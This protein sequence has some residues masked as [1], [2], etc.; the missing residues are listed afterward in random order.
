MEFLN[1]SKVLEFQS[2]EKTNRFL[3]SGWKLLHVG[4]YNYDNVECSTYIV[5]WPAEN[6][7][8]KTPESEYMHLD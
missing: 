2:Y 4:Q 3:D 7:E 5:G 6:G 8:V 1:F